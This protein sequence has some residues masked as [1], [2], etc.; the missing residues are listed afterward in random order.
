[1]HSPIKLNVLLASESDWIYLGKIEVS[2]LLYCPK[3]DGSR[4]IEHIQTASAMWEVTERCDDNVL[5][6]D[7]RDAS[8]PGKGVMK[9][10]SVLLQTSRVA[11]VDAHSNFVF[12]ASCMNASTCKRS[13][14]HRRTAVEYLAEAKR[15]AASGQCDCG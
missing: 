11:K 6:C 3:Y 1:M 7:H 4:R 2:A 9:Y 12:R 8:F 5:I 13:P 10:T 15:P 14:R